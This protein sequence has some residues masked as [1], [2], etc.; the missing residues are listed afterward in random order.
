VP[1]AWLD[2][3]HPVHNSQLPKTEHASSAELTGPAAFRATAAVSRNPTK[4]P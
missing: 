3:G 1:N 4:Q 2:A